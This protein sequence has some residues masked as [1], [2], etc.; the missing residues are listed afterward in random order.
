MPF[1]RSSLCVALGLLLALLAAPSFGQEPLGFQLAGP[2]DVSTFGGQPPLNEGYFFSFDGLYWSISPPKV[3]WVGHTVNGQPDTRTVYSGT[4]TTDGRVAT[5]TLDTS[6]FDAEFSVGNRIEFGRIEN[7]NGWFV[8][9]YQQRDQD[10]FIVAPGAEMVFDDPKQGPANV[11]LLYGNVNNN[12]STIPP[13]SPPV[14]KDLPAL[15]TNVTVENAIDTWSVE[16]NYLHRFMTSHSGGTFELFLGARYY[17]LNDNF[18]VRTG[19]VGG[20]TQGTTLLANGLLAVNKVPAF[21]DGSYWLTAAENHVVGPQI[22]MRWFK[23]QGRWMFSTEGRFMAGVNC[24]NVSQQVDMGPKLNPGARTRIL[25]Q[26][27]APFLPYSAQYYQPFQPLTMAHTTAT[28]G[29]YAQEWSPLIEMRVEG[30]YQITR[31]ISFHAGWTGW[32]IDGIAR[33]SS[34]VKYHLPDM[35]IDMLENREGVFVNGLTLGFDVNR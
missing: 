7:R 4:A 5:S 10:Q 27:I 12:G 16:A 21:L 2:V 1:N 28:H 17:E 35:G 8:S 9:I 15:F 18:R 34:L 30:R 6:Q 26:T 25:Y 13:Y 31:A 22:G 33:A 3:S 14:F 32:W 11:R 29:E 23:K 20:D 24:Q 19:V